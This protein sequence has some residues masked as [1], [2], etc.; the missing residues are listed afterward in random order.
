MWVFFVVCLSLATFQ[1]LQLFPSKSLKNVFNPNPP[2]PP[3]RGSGLTGLG[4]SKAPG[5]SAGPQALAL[6]LQA[7]GLSAALNLSFVEPIGILAQGSWVPSGRRT[8]L[9]TSK[10]PLLEMGAALRVCSAAA[11]YR[12][13]ISYRAHTSL[14]TAVTFN[15]SAVWAAFI[16]SGLFARKPYQRSLGRA[17]V[18]P[19]HS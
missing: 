13:A 5:D 16:R 7:P 4:F 18:I 6:A 17:S 10:H 1:C 3:P 15:C 8:R 2:V 11:E 19:Y 12:P 9:R 14:V